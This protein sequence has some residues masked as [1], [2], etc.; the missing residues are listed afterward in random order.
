MPDALSLPLI[1]GSYELRRAGASQMLIASDRRQ[2]LVTEYPV[3]REP[4]L[5]T[6]L[7]SLDPGAADL[8]L[9]EGFKWVDFPKIELHRPAMGKSLLFPQDR[10]IVAVATDAELNISTDLPVLDI[11]APAEV[12]D[13]V[14]RLAGIDPARYS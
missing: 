2:A 6:L 13:F 3:T 8:V 7:R 12:A 1:G 14:C 5:A 11:N 9:V 10:A 4:T